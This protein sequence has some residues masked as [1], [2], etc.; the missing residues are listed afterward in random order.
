MTALAAKMSPETRKGLAAVVS[1]GTA[2]LTP[3]FTSALALPGVSA[4]AKP[5]MDALRAKLDVLS[6]G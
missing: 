3:L 5:V 2:G 4:V 1:T 6:K